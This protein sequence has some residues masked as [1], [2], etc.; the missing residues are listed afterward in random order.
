ML[1]FAEKQETQESTLMRR[2]L[3]SHCS[4]SYHIRSEV[5]AIYYVFHLSTGLDSKYHAVE[6][7]SPKWRE[8]LYTGLPQIDT[9]ETHR[10]AP[11]NIFKHNLKISPS[12]EDCLWVNVY[13]M[14][15]FTHKEWPQ[16]IPKMGIDGGSRVIYSPVY[17]K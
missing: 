17:K 16:N 15:M 3:N 10:P 7:R 13:M 12:M 5:I 2:L 11:I 4:A 14:S 1:V 9:T 6:L 8:C